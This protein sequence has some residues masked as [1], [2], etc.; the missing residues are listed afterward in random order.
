MS[1]ESLNGASTVCSLQVDQRL[2]AGL[3]T[4]W[5]HE[6]LADVLQQADVLLQASFT[7]SVL[8]CSA[9][10]LVSIESLQIESSLIEDL[11]PF[12]A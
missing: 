8:D 7:A 6:T 5:R 2:L 4:S 3:P 1:I 10:I 11:R 12:E 9:E